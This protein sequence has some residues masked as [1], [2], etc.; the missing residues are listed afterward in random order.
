MRARE[1]NDDTGIGSDGGRVNVCVFLL[2]NSS[3]AFPDLLVGT[4]VTK[5]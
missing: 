3:C 5:R 4:K 2:D 1:G